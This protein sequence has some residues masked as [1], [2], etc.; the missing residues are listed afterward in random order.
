[1]ILSHTAD[2]PRVLTRNDSAIEQS[3]FSS[4]RNGLD[5]R[6]EPLADDGIPVLAGLRVRPFRPGSASS[7][8]FGISSDSLGNSCPAGSDLWMDQGEHRPILVS[9]PRTALAPTVLLRRAGRVLRSL[10]LLG[11]LGVLLP[12]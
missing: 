2:H 10:A 7:T 9:G 11:W 5:G 8:H 1:M 3:S 12:G 4:A 6:L